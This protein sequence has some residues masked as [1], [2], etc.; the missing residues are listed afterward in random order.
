MKSTTMMTTIRCD[1]SSRSSVYLNLNRRSFRNGVESKEKL[2][3]DT[4]KY[5]NKYSNDSLLYAFVSARFFSVFLCCIIYLHTYARINIP[6]AQLD[7]I[8]VF[9]PKTDDKNS[10]RVETIQRPRLQRIYFNML[11]NSFKN[12]MK[13]RRKVWYCW[14]D[15]KSFWEFERGELLFFSFFQVDLSMWM[16]SIFNLERLGVFT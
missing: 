10:K 4:K 6:H 7:F 11:S 1:T 9:S 15:E 2:S 14:T 3:L 8:Y 5:F 16:S 12:R 13:L